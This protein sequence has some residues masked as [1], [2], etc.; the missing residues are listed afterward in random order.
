MSNEASPLTCC[1]G[2]VSSHQ[3]PEQG[4]RL[5]PSRRGRFRNETDGNW[6]MW[7]AG[8]L[9]EVCF[10]RLR[11]PPWQPFGIRIDSIETMSAIDAKGAAADGRCRPGWPAPTRP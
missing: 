5:P 2:A 11:V 1:S 6:T 9:V 4:K 10:R 7:R 8:E 3:E